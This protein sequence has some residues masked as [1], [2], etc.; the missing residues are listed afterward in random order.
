M[1]LPK[2][3]WDV[4]P[5][6]ATLG[7]TEI[8]Y[9][10]LCYLLTL[11]VGHLLLSW[12]VQRGGGD[13]EEAGDFLTYGFVGLIVGARAGQVLFYD[14]DRF[15]HEPAWAFRIWTGGL[16]SHGAAAGLAVAMYWFTRR[17]A[18]PF[19]EG[20]DRLAFAIP[21]GAFLFRVGNLFNSEIV[22]KP[23]DGTWG[24]QFPRYDRDDSAPF[25][26]PTALYEMA[27]AA[28]VLGV[29]L[30]ADRRYG[31]EARPRGAITGILLVAL[32]SGRFVVEFLKEPQGDLAFGL[33]NPGQWLSVP[34]VLAG[35]VL[36]RWSYRGAR[37]AGWVIGGT[38]T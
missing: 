21:A 31:K 34:F 12:Q 29:L 10:P 16:A 27:L 23:T 2:V 20:C 14:F 8:R 3:V 26:H 9:Y 6:L 25:R 33:L 32:F 4:H 17:R 19:L 7:G 11:I 30:L 5:V 37:P 35:L 13:R 22:G 15:V 24:F 38:T 36:L 18:I 1:P 28:A